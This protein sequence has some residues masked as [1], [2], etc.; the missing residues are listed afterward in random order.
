MLTT[1]ESVQSIT[2]VIAFFAYFK[3]IHA[4]CNNCA[5]K[6]T[7]RVVETPQDSS[8]TGAGSSRSK[9]GARDS[10]RSRDMVTG[11]GGLVQQLTILVTCL[12]DQAFLVVLWALAET[13]PCLPV[14][15]CWIPIGNW[16]FGSGTVLAKKETVWAV[17]Y[18]S[19]NLQQ[20]EW[21]YGITE[22]KALGVVWVSSTT[23]TYGRRCDMFTDLEAL[24]ALLNTLHPSGKLAR[25]GFLFK[26][27]VSTFITAQGVITVMPMPCSDAKLECQIEMKTSLIKWLLYGSC[28]RQGPPCFGTPGTK[29][30]Y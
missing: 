3:S 30:L 9:H 17:A 20:H 10:G 22:L 18:A 14:P 28:K 6:P 23:S 4:L 25:W 21:N 7:V 24:K 2:T 5:S 16:Y 11:C 12:K 15:R 13:C 8:T 26:N 27:L 1:V 29:I 19:C